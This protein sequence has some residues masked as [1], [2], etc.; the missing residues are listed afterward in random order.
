ML[1]TDAGCVEARFPRLLARLPPFG[2]MTRFI[3]GTTSCRVLSGHR[4]AKRERLDDSRND[5]DHQISLPKRLVA[6]KFPL[7][8]GDPM[9][10]I[11][12][13][14]TMPAVVSPW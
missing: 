2:S 7:N 8:P 10:L 13:F 1:L 14:S 5:D 6:Q 9:V 11:L 3:Y 12:N 4:I